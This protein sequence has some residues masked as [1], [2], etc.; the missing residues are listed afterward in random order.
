MPLTGRLKSVFDRFK[1]LFLPFERMAIFKRIGDH[2][3]RR[4]VRTR[5]DG[6]DARLKF[7]RQINL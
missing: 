3:G 7:G 2:F 6:L 1:K 4:Q 5:G